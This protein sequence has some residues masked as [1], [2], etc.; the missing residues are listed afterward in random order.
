MR[1]SDKR[2]E[3]YFEKG[4]TKQLVEQWK[5]KQISPDR[6]TPDAQVLRDA[7]ILQQGIESPGFFLSLFPFLSLPHSLFAY[8]A[9]DNLFLFFNCR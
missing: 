4:Q 6:D 2:E 1:E 7:E 5:T 3:I 8:I 9:H